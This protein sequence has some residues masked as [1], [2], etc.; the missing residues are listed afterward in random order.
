MMRTLPNDLSDTRCPLTSSTVRADKVR[1]D[2][3]F[4]GLEESVNVEYITISIHDNSVDIILAHR[5]DDLFPKGT[6]SS[7][8]DFRTY[9]FIG[10]MCDIVHLNDFLC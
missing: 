8:V 2:I 10:I 5:Y 7:H 4:D 9:L 6:F 3:R 1:Y